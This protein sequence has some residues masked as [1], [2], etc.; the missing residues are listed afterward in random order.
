MILLPGSNYTSVGDSVPSGNAEALSTVTNLDGSTTNLIYDVH[1]YI[2]SDYTGTHST[3]AYTGIDGLE[4]LGDWLS[5]NGR[6][7]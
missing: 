7:A 6:Q 3:C 4:Y 2:D 5:T 1:Q